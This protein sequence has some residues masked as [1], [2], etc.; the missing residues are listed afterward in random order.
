MQERTG[1]REG[2]TRGEREGRGKRA[3][4]PLGCLLLTRA[5]FLAPIYFLAPATQAK[6]EL[7][8]PR[9]ARQCTIAPS[10]QP[11]IR[12][13]FLSGGGG[14]TQAIGNGDPSSNCP[15]KLTNKQTDKVRRIVPDHSKLKSFHFQIKTYY[16]S[17][18]N[19]QTNNPSHTDN[20]SLSAKTAISVINE[21]RAPAS[22]W[23]FACLLLLFHED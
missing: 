17:D 20:P 1:A 12:R 21:C 3:A 10:P 14:C 15:S 23:A 22:S 19:Y 11:P 6:I 16:L 7:E 9:E 8:Y 5:F 4:S 13:F 18:A 2:D